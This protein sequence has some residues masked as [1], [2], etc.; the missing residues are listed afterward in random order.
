M[1]LK[2]ALEAG[3]QKA[4]IS[5]NKSS[6]DLVTTLD[7]E[8][9]NI[10]SCLDRLMDITLFVDGKFGSFSTNRLS[11]NALKNFIIRAVDTVRI[12]APD[13]AR[14]LPDRERQIQG[15]LNGNE[16]AL[17]DSNYEKL[18]TSRRRK[19]ALNAAIWPLKGKGWK[20]ISEEGEYSDS[21]DYSYVIDSGGLE[22]LHSE[23]RFSY[24][25]EVTVEDSKGCKYSGYWW[26]SA[27][28]LAEL[29]FEGIGEKALEMALGRIGA[30]SVK[31]GKYNLVVD[32]EVS[33]KLFSP[34]LAS[35]SGYSIQQSNSFLMDSVGKKVF[36]EGLSVI[37]CPHIKGQN[38]S[39]LFD[40]EG[41][42]TREHAIIQNG[43]VKEFF[44]NTYTANK[45]CLSP[46]QEEAIRPKLMPYVK[47]VEL[48]QA[49]N[50]EE[51]MR[52]CGSGILVNY[53][54]GG[55]S[56]TATGDFSY[57]IEGFL[58]EDGKIVKPV[59]GML[60]TGNFLT[61]WSNLLAAGGD[62]RPCREKLI[63]SL[64]F[65]DVDFSG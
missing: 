22:A 43:V 28:F 54:N 24:E 48:S 45:L 36:S 63:P 47:G 64:A 30:K 46:T 58:F 29:K 41:V 1:A 62:A 27:P 23:T 12:L 39:R 35:L 34:V 21:L 16:L 33:S 56:N 51:L 49:L 59:S 4:R 37:D 6:M 13:S 57:G 3:A 25:A 42:A 11:E 14:D 26:D 31:S 61:L 17:Y 50:K 2:T 65:K 9:D 52:L 32:S 7:G 19:L 15:N 10:T 38:G 20:L 5:F 60:V 8:I 55:N 53:F 40:S 44:L 18:N